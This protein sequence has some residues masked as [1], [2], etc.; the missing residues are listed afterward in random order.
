M[1]HQ[2]PCPNCNAPTGRRIGTGRRHQ[3]I[4]TV[5]TWKSE[6]YAP[7]PG[8]PTRTRLVS[9]DG[10]CYYLYDTFGYISLASSS[11]SSKEECLKECYKEMNRLK[12]FQGYERVT[13]VVWPPSAEVDANMVLVVNPKEDEE[14]EFIPELLEEVRG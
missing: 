7:E 14:L 4:C 1:D 8:Q 10:W 3:D 6:L 9:L 13:V 12:K 11:Y 5:C 2:P